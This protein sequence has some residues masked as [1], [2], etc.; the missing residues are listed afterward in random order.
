MGGWGK[1]VCEHRLEDAQSEFSLSASVLG[2]S[3]PVQ[4]Q[5]AKRTEKEW[6]SAILYILKAGYLE[7]LEHSTVI[8]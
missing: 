6:V 7:T 2:L 8:A 5:K 1:H 4:E 3:R